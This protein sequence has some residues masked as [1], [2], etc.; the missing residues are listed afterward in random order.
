ML[1]RQMRQN[2]KI[3]MLVTALAFVALMVFE[4]GMDMSGQSSGGDLGRVGSTTVSVQ[5]W[6]NTYRGIYDQVSRT[7]D[8]P[9]SSQQNREIEDMAWDEI[10]NQ[11]LIEQELRRRGIRVSDDEIRIAARMAP[12]P[13]FRNEPAFLTDGRFDLQKYQAFLGQAAA[14]PQFV[15]QLEQ[16]YREVIPREKLIRQ[17]TAGIF[18]SDQELWEEYRGQNERVQISFFSLDPQSWIASSEVEIAARDV[19]R[20]YR[21]NRDDFAVPARAEL[22]YATLSKRL[23]AADSANSLERAQAVRQEILDGASFSEVARVES[24]DR[25]SAQEGGNLGSFRRG[26]MVEVFEEAAFSLPIG[27][28]S[29][30]ILSQFGYHIIEVLSRDDEQAEARHILIP[31]Q[32]SDDD[33]FALL[34][35]ADDIEAA[36]RN[37][38]LTDVAGEFQLDLQQG[39]ITEEFAI[40]PE[41]GVAGEAQDWIFEDMEGAGAVSPVFETSDAFYLVEILRESASGFLSLEDVREEITAFLRAERKMELAMERARS[42]AGE[43]QSGSSTLDGTADRLGRTVESPEPFTRVGFVPGL[44]ARNPAIGAA[45]GA[46]AGEFVGPVRA[47]GRIVFLRVEAKEA[48][49][50]EAFEAQK[51]GQR[52]QVLSVMRQNRIE[53]WLDGLREITRIQDRRADFFRQQEEMADRPQIPMAL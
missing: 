45:F 6:Q 32:R 2:T 14:D 34:R 38:P 46:P 37:R 50:P 42:L 40:L 22:L 36:A 49:S 26:Q 13:Q 28:V 31:V 44:G 47:E 7:Q 43:I 1:M 41:V 53:Q 4:W 51:E 20:F 12:P 48:A 52:Q 3:I 18:V 9:I 8:E 25:A 24:A 19:E 33:E 21:D 29:E 35:L 16:Y 15:R 11:I 27:E 23:T 39:E 10:V 17:V 5:A 30:P